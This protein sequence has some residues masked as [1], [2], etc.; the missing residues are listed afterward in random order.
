MLPRTTAFGYYDHNYLTWSSGV[1][2]HLP[3]STRPSAARAAVARAR[4]AGGAGDRRHRAAPGIRQQRPARHHAG[5]GRRAPTPSAMAR[6]PGRRAVVL[7]NNDSAYRAALDLAAAGAPRSPPSSTLGGQPKPIMMPGRSLSAKTRGRSMRAGRQH[8]LLGPDAP[9][10]LARRMGQAG[11]PGD[12]RPAPSRS[13]SCGRNSRRPWCAAAGVTS[14]MRARAATAS[15]SQSLA[16]LPSTGS[17]LDQS[18]EPPSSS[19]SSARMTRAR[20]LPATKA[21]ADARGTGTD[22]QNVAMGVGLARSDRDPARGRRA[23]TGGAA[24]EVLVDASRGWAAT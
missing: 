10:A 16:G 5:L 13:G 4:E 6:S 7:T 18:S 19:C 24:D 20:L 23:E 22:D 1:T 9:E 14:G 15:A 17:P 2:D 21:A 12:R 8:H 3:P 11:R